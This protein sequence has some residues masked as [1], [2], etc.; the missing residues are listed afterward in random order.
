MGISTKQL[1]DEK[2]VLQKTFDELNL[3]IR[4]VENETQK[5]RNNLNAVHGAMQEIDKLI[6]IDMVHGNGE[7]KDGFTPNEASLEIKQKEEARLLNE[8]E[9]WKKI[10]IVL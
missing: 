6:K 5:M 9:K 4:T 7:G 2:A 1:E 8:G 3:K 10:G